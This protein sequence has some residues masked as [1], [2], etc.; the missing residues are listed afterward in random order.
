MADPLALHLPK[1]FLHSYILVGDVHHVSRYFRYFPVE[2]GSYSHPTSLVIGRRRPAG[3]FAWEILL[4][5]FLSPSW[6]KD[7]GLNL[8]SL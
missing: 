5:G 3:T 7:H 4:Q 1:K 2:L 8:F 6:V